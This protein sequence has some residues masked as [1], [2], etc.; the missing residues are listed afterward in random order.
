MELE[1]WGLSEDLR[2][3]F[4]D[5]IQKKS[6]FL[7]KE[8]LTPTYLP[9]SLLHRNNQIKQLGTILAPLLRDEIPSNILVFGFTGVGKTIV[10]KYVSGELEQMAKKHGKRVKPIYI[11]CK[12]EKINTQYRLLARLATELGQL[13]PMTGLPTDQVYQTFLRLLNH[14]N[15]NL[16]VILD[17]IDSMDQA[18]NA[19]YDLTR[20]NYEITNG[21]RVCVIGISNKLNF[22]QDLDPKVRS[23]FSGEELVFPPYN[24]LQLQDILKQRAEKAFL[25]GVAPLNIISKCSAL[26]AQEHGDARRAL[27]LLRV[28]AEVADRKGANRV[29]EEHVGIAAEKLEIEG[30]CNVVRTLPKQSQALLW[31]I[32]NLN[33]SDQDLA[34]GDVYDQYSTT[35]NEIGLSPLTQRRVSDLLSELDILG[36][37]NTKVISKGRY[38]RTRDIHLALTEKTLLKTTQILKEELLID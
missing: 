30:T 18:S 3:I 25:P 15:Q 27:T 1:V 11:N 21:S 34:T 31:A 7:N 37:I 12:M 5:F 17:E 23:S 14:K 6:I 19:L 16:L 22:M 9:E 20:V 38:G 33:S 28:S 8:A 32:L 26:A 36:I 10:A 4:T 13:V 24:A 2:E 35:C 29:V